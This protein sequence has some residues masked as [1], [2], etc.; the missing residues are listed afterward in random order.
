MMILEPPEEL[1]KEIQKNLVDFFWSGQHW[2]RA[3]VLYL[4]IQEGG[5]GLVDIS[6]RIR[7]FR[8]Q[9]ARR[10]LYGEHV[11]WAEVA[12]S[13]LRRAGN[14]GLDRHL[15]L[16]D[17]NKLDLTGLTPFYRSVLRAWTLLKIS[18]EPNG[19]LDLWMREEP[20]LLNPALAL[21]IF[22]SVSL[23]RALWS[24]NITKVGLLISE[25]GW[26]SAEN[27]AQ[28][29]DIRSV[30]VVERMLT[31]IREFLPQDYRL[32][33]ESSGGEEE[34]STF[35]E[36]A[37]S[38]ET[39]IWQE[40]E[41]GLLSFKTPQLELFSNTGKKAFYVLCVKVSHLHSLESV[42]E[43]KWQEFF[44][45]GASPKGCWRSLYKT[46]IEKR[47]GD[48]QWRIVHG[49]IATNRHRAHLD[50][51][52]AGS[53]EKMDDELDDE[54]LSQYTD[55]GMK[56]DEWPEMTK[57]AEKDLYSVEQIN[58][59]LD[60]TKVYGVTLLVNFFGCMAWMFG[61]GGV[62]N[63]GMSIIW[64][65]LFT[66]CSYVCWFRSI[67]NA[68]KTDSSFYF[69]AFFFVFMAQ[70]FISIIQAIGI[71]GWGVCGWLGT[72]SFFGTSIFAS[73]IMLIPTLMFTAVAAICFIALT[74]VH[75]FYRGSGGSMSKAQEEWVS[76]AWKN[77]HVQQAAQQA[78]LGSLQGP[79]T[80]QTP[81]YSTPSYDNT[82]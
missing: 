17:I 59:F 61:G 4:P 1:V 76:G 46:P 49:I 3:P 18:R 62:T 75:N 40:T 54:C 13:L 20:L 16:M 35:P 24:A 58:S 69:M 15:F 72:I 68:F 2:L 51:Q 52:V 67:Y 31:Q 38:A 30:R 50:P 48:L 10:L 71:P 57:E 34:T 42:R 33:L 32:V 74:K 82:M 26:I 12:C 53:Q 29:L 7:A 9:A 77:P 11:S 36:L 79:Q 66:P 37:F 28:K 25:D 6:S 60:Q 8:L 56:D 78:A 14:M 43:S 22:N 23:R 55:D 5:Q 73:I 21:D 39:G 80:P 65:V 27:L 64:V 47:S 63:F 70:L 41:G 44:G 81:Q 45:P 19:A